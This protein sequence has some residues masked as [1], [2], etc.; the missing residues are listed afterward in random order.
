M[1]FTITSSSG[2]ER[3]VCNQL[4]FV[5]DVANV[6][7]DFSRHGSCSLGTGTVKFGKNSTQNYTVTADP[8]YQIAY[9]AYQGQSV[10]AA[11]G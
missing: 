6:T 4:L 9:L 8:G 1:N 11:K 3:A 2:S 5:E 7:M 10:D